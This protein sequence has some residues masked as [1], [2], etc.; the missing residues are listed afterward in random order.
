MSIKEVTMDLEIL[1]VDPQNDFCVADDGHGNKGSLC[2]AGADADIS[3][4]TAF[5]RRVG[6][7]LDDIHVTLDSHQGVGI[8]RPH[9]WKRTSDGSHPTP[10]TILGIHPDGKRIVQF[11]ADASGLHPT[12]EEY[13]TTIPSF[14]HQ[15]GA[16]GKGSFGYLQALA[17]GGKY[18][19]VIWP[20]HCVVGSWGMRSCRK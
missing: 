2:V 18:P 12:E 17:A 8:E 4:L 15:G 7:K 14:L 3:R 11:T 5:L 16:T 6:H 9:W 19:H 13:T 1:I 20:I 10:F